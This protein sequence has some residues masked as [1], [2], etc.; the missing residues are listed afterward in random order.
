ME[1][2]FQYYFLISTTGNPLLNKNYSSREKGPL[3]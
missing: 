1:I 3:E 2:Y